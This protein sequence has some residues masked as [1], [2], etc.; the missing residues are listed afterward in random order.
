MLLRATTSALA[1]GARVPTTTLGRRN[2]SV[3]W[4]R[5]PTGTRQLINPTGLGD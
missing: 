2:V 1:R 3:V 4:S 5:R